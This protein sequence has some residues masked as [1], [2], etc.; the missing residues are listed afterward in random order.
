MR[1]NGLSQVWDLQTSDVKFTMW[2]THAMFCYEVPSPSTTKVVA[3]PNTRRKIACQ[4]P[5]CNGQA[6]HGLRNKQVLLRLNPYAA[7]YSKQKL[8][9]QSVEG[10]KPTAPAES[11]LNTLYE[12]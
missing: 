12:N 5:Q 6:K 2:A 9:Q 8:G 3:F 10:G 1:E 11:F 7:A 4:F